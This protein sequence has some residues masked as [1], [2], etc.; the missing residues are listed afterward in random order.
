MQ[1]WAPFDT[2]FLRHV[3]PQVDHKCRN[4]LGT[5]F[6]QSIAMVLQ[7][8][9]ILFFN[10]QIRLTTQKSTKQNA[11]NK[12]GDWTG[13]SID[14]CPSG[15]RSHIKTKM[16]WSLSEQWNKSKI[17]LRESLGKTLFSFL[18]PMFV[19]PSC[20]RKN[21]KLLIVTT[22]NSFEV[23]GLVALSCNPSF[24]GDKGCRIDPRSGLLSFC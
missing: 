11:H 15:M 17:V 2:I 14:G 9:V 12:P 10:Y 22:Q 20:Y 13:K 23:S 5:L 8:E 6:F 18:I 3:K 16:R 19:N 24:L 4:E 1:W 7:L 21:S